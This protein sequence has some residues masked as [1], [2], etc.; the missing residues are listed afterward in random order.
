MQPNPMS[1]SLLD[2]EQKLEAY[3]NETFTT[4]LLNLYRDGQDSNGWHADNEKELGVNPVIASVS[5]G[6]SRFFHL[7]HN[8]DK[9]QKLK[10]ELT[11]GSLLLMEGTTQ[12]FWKHQIAKTA[13]AVAPRINLTFRKVLKA[14]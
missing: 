13:K 6:A 14:H 7:K 4:V 10:L 2:I 11:H 3:T 5:L 9:S 12:H 8:T 1:K